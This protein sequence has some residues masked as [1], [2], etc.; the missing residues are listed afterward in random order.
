MSIIKSVIGC[1]IAISM[2]EAY[3]NV[4][5]CLANETPTLN[6]CNIEPRWGWEWT[7]S[8][9]GEIE[10]GNNG[11]EKAINFNGVLG[12]WNGA[13]TVQISSF[14]DINHFDK[15]GYTFYVKASTSHTL[16]Q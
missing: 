10:V 8:L 12:F 15:D 4:E 14:L 6:D 16:P 13:D 7:C 3:S 9:K 5:K 11:F 2:F 1:L